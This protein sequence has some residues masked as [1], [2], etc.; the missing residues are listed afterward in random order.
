[1]VIVHIYLSYPV[2]TTRVADPI[3]TDATVNGIQR[4]LGLFAVFVLMSLYWGWTQW[5][6][7]RAV[8]SDGPSAI[9]DPS[10]AAGLGLLC[11]SV[12]AAGYLLYRAVL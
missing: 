11:I 10:E 6:V 8:L 9:A 5:D 12:L 7:L 1:M 4:E 2:A 3:A